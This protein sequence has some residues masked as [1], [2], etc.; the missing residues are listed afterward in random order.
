MSKLKWEK[1]HFLHFS[2][3][4]VGKNQGG[5]GYFVVTV[6][7]CEVSCD[8]FSYIY[9]MEARSSP[10]R[11]REREVGSLGWRIKES[12]ITEN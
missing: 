12:P 4:K 11:E 1:M 5:G 2:R 8:Y 6:K 10:R 7:N 3:K 9:L